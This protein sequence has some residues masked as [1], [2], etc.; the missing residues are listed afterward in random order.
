MSRC[1]PRKHA[2]QAKVAREGGRTEKI[3]VFVF[4]CPPCGIHGKTF[5][6][7]AQRDKLAAQHQ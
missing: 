2:T 3:T 1:A 5:E 6:S 4:S 7:R